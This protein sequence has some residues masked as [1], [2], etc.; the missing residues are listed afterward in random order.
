MSTLQKRLLLFIIFT[1]VIMS[2]T[3][4]KVVVPEYT[5]YG[6]WVRLITD[7]HGIK[8]NAELR[9]KTDNSFEFILLEDVPGHTNSSGKFTFSSDIITI[10]KDA[11]CHGDGVYEFVVSEKKLALIVVTDKCAPRV[12]ALQGVWNKK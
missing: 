11:D 7:T 8:F 9:I 10:I 2:C 3:R 1:V 4:E 6:S 5:I 12:L